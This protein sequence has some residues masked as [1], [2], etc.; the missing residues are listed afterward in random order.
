MADVLMARP[1]RHQR[2]C[3]HAK[4]LCR[5]AHAATRWILVLRVPGSEWAVPHL[6]EVCSQFCN[7]WRMCL[8]LRC[9]SRATWSAQSDWMTRDSLRLVC[10]TR[11]KLPPSTR[12]PSIHDEM[13]AKQPEQVLLDQNAIIKAAGSQFLAVDSTAVRHDEGPTTAILCSL[14][15]CC[16][17]EHANV[18]DKPNAASKL[19]RMA[20]G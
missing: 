8:N 12:P 11:R 3:R 10:C 4:L 9:I 13:D 15:L 20:Y 5:L 2:T 19:G 14:V 7:P 6:C 18:R 1:C 16:G 17:L